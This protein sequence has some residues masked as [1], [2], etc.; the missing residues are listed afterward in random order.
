[1]RLSYFEWL[2][3][4]VSQTPHPRSSLAFP[5]RKPKHLYG[6][7]TQT[8]VEGPLPET[9]PHNPLDGKTKD[10]TEVFNQNITF[11]EPILG[12]HSVSRCVSSE[13]HRHTTIPIFVTHLKSLPR[14]YSTI[15]A[16][17]TNNS[18]SPVPASKP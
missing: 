17:H 12:K 15:P 10:L 7:A 4:N 8:S 2:F 13:T 16:L 5:G 6:A 9:T 11:K 14:K 3:T 18:P 1:M